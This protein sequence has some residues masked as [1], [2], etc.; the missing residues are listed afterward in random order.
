MA[1]EFV[2]LRINYNVFD[3]NATIETNPLLDRLPKHLKQFIKPQDY[4]DYAHQSG[5]VALCD[6]QNVN[7]LRKWHTILISMV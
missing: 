3:M 6:A 7:Y 5:S 4:S 1:P 2:L